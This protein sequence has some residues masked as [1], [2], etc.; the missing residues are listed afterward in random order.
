M[1]FRAYSMERFAAKMENALVVAALTI[2][3][4]SADYNKRLHD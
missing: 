2:D 3:S 4:P 1:L